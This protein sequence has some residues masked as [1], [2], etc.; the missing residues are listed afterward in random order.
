MASD[1]SHVYGED[2]TVDATGDLAVSDGSQ[3]GVERIL[4][5]L[6][7]NPGGYI[8]SLSYGGG[9]A[10][11]LGHPAAANR[12]AAVVRSQMFLEAA[13]A[14]TPAPVINVKVQPDSTVIVN[15]RYADADTGSGVSLSIPVQG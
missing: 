6:L 9:L 11:F 8:W 2:L 14:K 7:T 3:L 13:V 5:R 12:I 1:I 15:I 4:R 10:A